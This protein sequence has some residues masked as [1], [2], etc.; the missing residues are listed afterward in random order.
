[1][2]QVGSTFSK[3][4]INRFEPRLRRFGCVAQFSID[5]EQLVDPV[6]DGIGIDGRRPGFS[7]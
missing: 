1:V 3:R 7:A 5:G 2:N 6:I 4:R